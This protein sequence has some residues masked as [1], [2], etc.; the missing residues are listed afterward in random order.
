MPGEGHKAARAPQRGADQYR[1]A[2][3]IA[4]YHHAVARERFQQP[5]NA[6]VNTLET[7]RISDGKPGTDFA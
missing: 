1:R 5:S 3:Y 2:R 7:G 6:D 4:R